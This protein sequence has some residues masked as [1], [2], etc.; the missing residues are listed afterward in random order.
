MVISKFFIYSWLVNFIWIRCN[1]VRENPAQEMAI[2]LQIHGKQNI[3]NDNIEKNLT[4]RE[5]PIKNIEASSELTD[6]FNRKTI[7]HFISRKT[8]LTYT[9]SYLSYLFKIKI[10]Q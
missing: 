4:S 5:A 8:N 6:I 10:N 1:N 9:S 2:T 7:S 3:F